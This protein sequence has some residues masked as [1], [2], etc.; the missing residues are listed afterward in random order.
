MNAPEIP[1]SIKAETYTEDFEE[2][3]AK[4]QH[5]IERSREE[6]GISQDQP[7]SALCFS[8]GG[9]RSAAFN[10]GVLQQLEHSQAMHRFDYLSTVSGGGY[11]GACYSYI[12]KHLGAGI[13]SLKGF[14]DA[15]LANGNGRAIDWLREHG[16]YLINGRGFSGWTLAGAILSGMTL[17]I[18]VI[19]PPLLLALWCLSGDFLPQLLPG[20]SWPSWLHLPGAQS[21]ERHDGFM[22]LL[23]LSLVA[24][25]TSALSVVAFALNSAFMGLHGSLSTPLSR[26]LRVSIGQFLAAGCYLGLLGLTPILGTVEELV[27]SLTQHEMSRFLA[28]H[29]SYLIPM[30]LGAIGLRKGMKSSSHSQLLLP[31]SLTLL[32]VGLLVLSYH[33]VNKGQIIEHNG[34]WVFLGISMFFALFSQLNG[35]SLH[36]YYRDRLAKA[37]LVPVKKA[38]EDDTKEPS[39]LQDLIY[40]ELSDVIGQPLPIINTTVNTSS[41]RCEKLRN[42]NG[43]SLF[44]SPLHV[45]SSATGFRRTSDY[46]NDSL[47]LSTLMAVSGAAVAP[48]TSMSRSRV[49]SFLLAFLNFRLGV[50]LPNPKLKNLRH[51]WFAWYRQIGSEM[52]GVHL[53]P[54]RDQILLSDGGHFDNLGLYEMLRRQVKF[55]VCTDASADSRYGLQAMAE[56]V[57]KARSDFNIEIDLDADTLMTQGALK[58]K[59]YA[60]GKIY[61]PDGRQ[62]Q[63]IYLKA[64]L[65]DNLPVDLSSYAKL[66]PAFPNQSTS[67]QFFDEM[68]YDCYRQLGYC[69]TA[70]LVKSGHLKS[71]KD[72]T[73]ER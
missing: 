68:Q 23:I 11:I 52:L 56:I 29:L 4:E 20:F 25:A 7:S 54:E 66:N 65:L 63:L 16:K 28:L 22:A 36:S 12:R 31:V 13:K 67:D 47:P 37:F 59:P 32:C 30:I 39:S 42:R 61:Y 19:W 46:L 51:R 9:V 45:G 21:V 43:E 26:H 62:G 58:T 3:L 72:K 24:F 53:S 34:Y 70:E 44:F 18:L 14:S 10:L 2:V 33:L 6:R 41:S 57:Q 38:I 69:L 40:S 48:D 5:W 73:N 35:V 60:V 71:V 17:N 1:T 8:G 15:P 49:L 64:C 55:I 50:W 27:R